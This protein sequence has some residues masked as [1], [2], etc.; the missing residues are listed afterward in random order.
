MKALGPR[1]SVEPQ[2]I[3][4][5]FHAHLYSTAWSHPSI[6]GNPAWSAASGKLSGSR[7]RIRIPH[8]TPARVV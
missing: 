7:S 5:M 8:G 2:K 1:C 4:D 6:C 3:I